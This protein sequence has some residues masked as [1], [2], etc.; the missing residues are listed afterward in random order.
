MNK[1][2]K[3]I[4]IVVVLVGVAVLLVFKSEYIGQAFAALGGGFAAFKAKLFNSSK[5]SVEEDIS[6]IETEHTLK[7]NHW[8]LMKEE[9][10]SKIE[11]LKARMDYLDYKS[12]SISKQI[13]DLTTAEKEALKRNASLSDEELLNWLRN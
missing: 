7:R 9:Y 6:A 2:L 10:D 11:A 1:S 3:T 13:G 8:E 5:I 12:A 4:I